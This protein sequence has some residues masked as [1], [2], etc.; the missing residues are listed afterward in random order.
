MV[1]GC[2]AG[3]DGITVRLPGN[4]G[5][6]PGQPPSVGVIAVGLG[7]III[8]PVKAPCAVI[9]FFL[10]LCGVREDQ[11]QEQTEKKKGFMPHE[12]VILY[13]WKTSS[14]RQSNCKDVL[15]DVTPAGTLRSE[16]ERRI[17]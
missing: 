1:P 13:P 2:G 15:S 5:R 14:S 7:Q 17:R 10:A 8:F 11:N 12:W 4:P 16:Q 3:R 6:R 9:V